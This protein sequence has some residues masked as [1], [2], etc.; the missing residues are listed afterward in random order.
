MYTGCFHVRERLILALVVCLA[1]AF[2]ASAR[3]LEQAGDQP[4][5]GIYGGTGNR[6]VVKSIELGVDVLFPAL[7]WFEPNLFAKNIVTSVRPHGIK[8]YPSLAVAYDGSQGKLHPFAESSRFLSAARCRVPR[9]NSPTFA[10]SRFRS[11]RF[12]ACG[13]HLQPGECPHIPQ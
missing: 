1:P 12:L 8:V 10:E 3:G 6:T 5:V 7:N 4:L 11:C 13:R 2:A 9:R